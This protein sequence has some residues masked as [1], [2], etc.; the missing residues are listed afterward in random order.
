M[1]RYMDWQETTAL[2]IVMAT[3]AAFAW[4]KLRPRKFSFQKDTHCGCSSQ[5]SSH[6]LQSIVLR[7]RKGER[8]EVIVK[9]K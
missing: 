9:M 4:I 7:A 2:A 5:A 6:Q 8:A 3:V 1:L